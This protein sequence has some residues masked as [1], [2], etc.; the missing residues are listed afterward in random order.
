[1]NRTYRL[2]WNELSQRNV[3]APECARG[4]G[5]DKGQALKPAALVLGLAFGMA[6]ALPSLGAAPSPNTLPTG[7]QLVAG[8]AVIGQSG[9]QMTITQ[10]SQRAILN[11]QGFDIGSQASVHFNQP[12]A[13]AVTLN[14]VIAGEASQI[15]GK[16]SANGQV[17]L[18]NPNG[19]VFG[20][21]SRVDVGSLV[22]STLDT[23]NEDFL[24]GK[25]I[26][27][28][29]GA[30]GS[31]LNQGDLNATEGGLVALLA[32][33]VKND[34]IISTRL[35]NATLAAGDR[36]TLDAGANGLLKVALE[37]ATV[38]TLIENRQLIVADGGQVLMTSKAA[39]ALAASVVANRGT[40]R[41]SSVAE[42]DGRI[43]LVADMQHGETRATGTL[44]AR[45]VETSAAR[46]GIDKNLKVSTAGGQWLIDPVDITIDAAKATAIQGALGSGNVTVSTVNGAGNSW[47]S[48]GSASDPGD[49]HVNSPINWSANTLSLNAERHINI[50]AAL[51]GSGTAKL[52]LAYGQG[53][54]AAGN[55]AD[56]YVNAK[57][58][59]PAGNNFS[60]KLGSDGAIESYTVITSLGAPGS[61]TGTDLQGMSG[62]L[63]GK[64]ALGGDIDASATSGWNGGQGFASVGNDMSNFMGCFDGLGHAISGVVISRLNASNQ[65]MFGYIGSD[66]SV[67][68]IGLVGSVSGI[69]QT[70]GIAGANKGHISN[71]YVNGVIN[72]DLSGGITGGLVGL[73]YGSIIN[74][75]STGSVTGI[76][77]VGGLVGRNEG[78]VS[79]SYA[80][81][82][83]SG[84][85]FTGGLVGTSQGSISSSFAVGSVTGTTNTGGLVGR[86]LGYVGMSFWN[87]QTSGKSTSAG[88]S[89][90]TSAE[91]K[92]LANFTS[93]TGANGNVNPGWD[94]TTV[95]RIYEGQSYPVLRALQ[96]NLT[97]TANNASKSYDGVAY[98]GG[99]GV[100]YSANGAPLTGT[101]VYSGSSQGPV[102]AS[103]YTITPSGLSLN[104]VTHQDFQSWGDTV[105]F[106]NGTLTIN[107]VVLTTTIS[108]SLIGMVQK[109][110]DG[111][112]VAPL[113]AGNFLLTG[114]VGSDGATVTKAT[115]TYDNA[116]AGS[117]KTV[118]VSLA[119]G[120][121]SA[122]GSTNLANYVL[123]TSISG[124]VGVIDKALLSVTANDASK[125]ADGA[126]WT[127]GN[128]VVYAGFVSG[129][130]STVLGGALSY[131][132]NS[133]GAVNAGSYRIT[134]GG[135]SS[136]NYGI[137]YHDGTLRVTA[138]PRPVD[139]PITPPANPG[140]PPVPL[141]S[142]GTGWLMPTSGQI[143]LAERP[144]SQSTTPQGVGPGHPGSF[145]TGVVLGMAES[146][147][148]GSRQG[149]TMPLLTLAPEIIRL[150]AE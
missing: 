20:A 56:Y 58:N 65:G 57:V 146:G 143:W 37:P 5:K 113:N 36:V 106:A 10:G 76:N 43:L 4:Q 150:N 149:G 17:W 71:V 136:G 123:P 112:T 121:Y 132:G 12:S 97:I 24:A 145:T 73:N 63:A 11:W 99:N 33:T 124:K 138:A 49:I 45:F 67:R 141:F 18:V 81:S 34:G 148:S 23:T 8:Q 110:Y 35:G 72:G 42:K 60:T 87:I 64:Y 109:I 19:V 139:P 127:G 108:G 26:F 47:G 111:S 50:N 75:Y 3:P 118:T 114:W 137:T 125:T 52:A 9:K 14:R 117:G 103:S 38:K 32:P 29:Q 96:H 88:G 129:E 79:N 25:A 85:A 126:P 142:D 95:W 92:Q 59:L 1:M 66:G 61:T 70:G 22:A 80:T 83:V 39:D 15:H 62:N 98:A 134:P 100:S 27:R 55:T 119:N 77:S 93:A 28:R 130:T 133:Q 46:V 91:M 94:F 131:S 53:A 40:V 44:E 31:I 105:S 115:G 86:N 147:N 54:V 78:N 135:L 48:N 144:A 51:N 102:N 84:G 7:G 128:G 2:V 6:S 13:S 41:A 101:L 122:T 107:P 69:F 116:N 68:N 90:M 89:G 140:T 74:S 16:L 104:R 120:D 30:T 21:G 82:S